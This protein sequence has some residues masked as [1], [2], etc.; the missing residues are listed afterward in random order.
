MPDSGPHLCEHLQV[1][2]TSTSGWDS[3]FL[4]LFFF[5]HA[6]CGG[7]RECTKSSL[8]TIIDLNPAVVI[9]SGAPTPSTPQTPPPSPMASSSSS[10]NASAVTSASETNRSMAAW[11]SVL[12][13][14]PRSSALR[15]SVSEEDEKAIAEKLVAYHPHSEDKIGCGLESIMVSFASS[16]SVSVASRIF[17]FRS[18]SAMSTPQGSSDST[19]TKTVHAITMGDKKYTRSGELRQ[20]LG[21]SFGNT[22]EDYAFGTANLKPPPPVAMEE[23]KRFKASVQEASV[24]ARKQLR[25]DLV[26]NERLGGSKF[27]KMG[28]QTHRSPSE[29]VNQRP[30]DRPK[31]V[32]LNKVENE[33]SEKI[34]KLI[35][36]EASSYQKLLMKRVEENL[37]SI[38][39]SKALSVHNSVME[40]HNICNHPYLSQL[41]AEEDLQRFLAES[42]AGNESTN[43]TICEVCQLKSSLLEGILVVNNGVNADVKMKI[44]EGGGKSY[45]GNEQPS[46]SSKRKVVGPS[47]NLIAQ[48][49]KDNLKTN[50]VVKQVKTRNAKGDKNPQGVRVYIDQEA[51]TYVANKCELRETSIPH[52]DANVDHAIVIMDTNEEVKATQDD[53]SSKIPNPTTHSS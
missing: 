5:I 19:S 39:N 36:C 35:R 23:L 17:Q 12:A 48:M 13:N 4:Y 27:S 15:K 29:L 28:T 31:N 49:V 46:S 3:L 20:V 21:I 53:I 18:I 8:S 52:V 6:L 22:L 2:F 37:G 24:R 38:G 50:Q 33:L 30:E 9:L 51:V 40:L 1:G 25:N 26:P 45:I 41:H 44:M 16:S 43:S 11:K 42:T 34:E 7:Q 32:I 10:F 14:P 47:L